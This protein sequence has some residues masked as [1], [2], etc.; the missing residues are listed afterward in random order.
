MGRVKEEQPDDD[1]SSIEGSEAPTNEE[2]ASRQKVKGEKDM[3]DFV[4]R[5]DT[6]LDDE[7]DDDDDDSTAF[8]AVDERLAPFHASTISGIN[9]KRNPDDRTEASFGWKGRDNDG[10]TMA[11][12]RQAKKRTKTR[13]RR[14][15]ACPLPSQTPSAD[16]VQSTPVTAAAG[17]PSIGMA[18]APSHSSPAPPNSPKPIL[19]R[20][21]SGSSSTTG[22]SADS[23]VSPVVSSELPRQIALVPYGAGSSPEAPDKIVSS[24]PKPAPSYP[25]ALADNVTSQTH[26]PSDAPAPA[27]RGS[28]TRPVR[29]QSGIPASKKHSEKQLATTGITP[30][31]QDPLKTRAFGS[32]VK[33]RFAGKPKDYSTFLELSEQMI[34][35]FK[36]HNSSDLLGNIGSFFENPDGVSKR[37][38]QGVNPG[39]ARAA[40]PG[41][42][43]S[44]TLARAKSKSRPLASALPSSSAIAEASRSKGSRHS[45]TRDSPPCP[46]RTRESIPENPIHRRQQVPSAR[47]RSDKNKYV[48]PASF[49][50]VEFLH[51]LEDV[52]KLSAKNVNGIIRPANKLICGEGI[53]YKRWGKRVFKG[54]IKVTLSDD[55][56]KLLNEAKA[57]ENKHGEDLGHGWLMR[58]SIKKLD[59]FKTWYKKKHRVSFMELDECTHEP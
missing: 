7:D 19:A 41:S 36:A 33:E 47:Q 43:T 11:R 37:K 28:V 5:E 6:L 16:V 30:P 50:Q 56:A 46:H 45:E 59:D 53:R 23:H 29:P 3:E 4:H 54:N 14:G 8:A 35:L 42:M 52:Q 51:F 20:A 21:S 18:P 1:D 13:L 49:P 31:V 15:G 9:K 58:H 44:T 22:S 48:F 39:Q 40:N 10:S 34:Q 38:D 25:P 27:D 32:L 17:R 26:G 12:P 55:L 24:R 57:F 2:A